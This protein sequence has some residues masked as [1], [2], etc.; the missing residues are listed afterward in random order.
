MLK[1]ASSRSTFGRRL[2]RLSAMLQ[3]GLLRPYFFLRLATGFFAFA[4][5]LS[6]S[7]RAAASE[8]VMLLMARMASTAPFRN[9]SPPGFRSQR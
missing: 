3:L 1:T 4:G 8:A 7:S 9:F 5:F 2:A 6:C